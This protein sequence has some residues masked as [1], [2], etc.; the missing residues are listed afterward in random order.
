[1]KTNRAFLVGAIASAVVSLAA[2]VLASNITTIEGQ[3][4][5]SSATLDSSPVITT[6]MSQ[7][8]T[9]NGHTFTKWAVLATDGTG[10][11]D[12]YSAMPSGNTYIPTVG[13]AISATGT[14]SPYSQIP[15]M[16]T[17]TAISQVSSGNP[18]P[19]NQITT[20]SAVTA[21]TTIPL[22]LAGYPLEIDNVSLYTDSGATTLATG[23]FPNGNA[24]YYIKD[25]GGNIMEVYFWVTSYSCDAAM[26]GTPIPT[27]PFN[28][29]GIVDESSG[30]PVEM[31]PYLVPEPSMFALVGLGVA[32]LFDPPPAPFL[33]GGTTPLFPR[34]AGPARR[35]F[36][37]PQAGPVSN[38]APEPEADHRPDE[39]VQPL[40]L[41]CLA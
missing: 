33:A 34:R 20:I 21:S 14:Y 38:G 26:I 1:M 37:V 28:I 27:V 15:E 22:S 29:A 16:A 6:I 5:G 18:V 2:N 41:T 4:S 32:G 23:N 17:L 13:D 25:S 30:Y 35:A 24:T 40:Q 39:P 11:I 9:T 10:S 36:C 31:V 19:A 3:T 12:L 8:I 7:P